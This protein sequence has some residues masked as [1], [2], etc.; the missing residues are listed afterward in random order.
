M[1]Q[2][3]PINLDLAG[4]D[5]LVVGGGEV[6]ERKVRRLLEYGAKVIVVSPKATAGIC[7]L[8][9]AGKIRLI[10][11]HVNLR[12]ITGKFLVI[13]AAGER[14]INYLVSRYCKEAGILVNVAD[15]P[16]EC[17]FILPSVVKRGDLTISISTQGASPALAKKIRQD[18]EK[19]FGPEYTKLLK[20]MKKLR[21][22]ALKKIKDARRRKTFFE[23]AVKSDVLN[24]L[25]Q[26]KGK[27]AKEKI[28]RL[29]DNLL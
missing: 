24:L 4:K 3:Y 25:K 16:A 28:G 15:S 1:T 12:D 18:L 2:Y 13:S 14:R 8:V 26:D 23:K 5:C 19:K 29:L 27:N 9:K 10:K 22:E 17:N 6:A 21:P 7:A 20:I 11:S